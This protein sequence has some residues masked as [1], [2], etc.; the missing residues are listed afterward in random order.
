MKK[1]EISIFAI[2]IIQIVIQSLAGSEIN[3]V[4]T[5]S[6]IFTSADLVGAGLKIEG[7]ATAG[8]NTTLVGVNLNNCYSQ[9]NLT[10]MSTNVSGEITLGGSL[11]LS[12]SNF[13]NLTRVS[14]PLY[15]F[16]S[17]RQSIIDNSTSLGQIPSNG[18]VMFSP[19]G[20]LTLT[21]SDPKFNVFRIANPNYY[22]SIQIV[23]PPHATTIVNIMGDKQFL[24]QNNINSFKNS[25]L[26]ADPSLVLFNFPQA[27]NITLN[28]SSIS[29]TLLA[30]LAAFSI[31]SC[32][33]TGEIITNKLTI[34]GTNLVG[35]SYTGDF[36][37]PH[38]L[39]EAGSLI[40]TGICLVLFIMLKSLNTNGARLRRVSPGLKS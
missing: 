3:P 29:A 28:N 14:S 6:A 21:G 22:T 34:K 12:A 37:P 4:V 19:N 24:L 20:N 35:M 25:N 39:P 8:G 36:E 18:T 38:H 33:L 16:P 17:I 1:R 40:F 31:N 10:L 5:S 26:N 15:D 27:K 30:P 7:S 11:S 32:Q 23:V 9:G 2:L 13:G